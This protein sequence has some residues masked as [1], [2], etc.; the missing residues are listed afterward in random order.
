MVTRLIW[1][2][3][4]ERAKMRNLLFKNLT[5]ND[6][7]RR[8]VS[9]SEISER[10]GVRSVIRRHF[11][12]IVKEVSNPNIE[13]P[14]PY[15]YVLKEQDTKEQRQKFFCKLKGSILAI[16]RGKLFLIVFMHTLKID[17]ISNPQKV[18]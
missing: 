6:R 11:I 5:S 14:K 4:V 13:K 2:S 9:S 3:E 10:E 8:V 18:A 12:Y 1:G 17:L 15:L 16:N 7:K